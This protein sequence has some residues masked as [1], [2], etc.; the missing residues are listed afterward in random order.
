M[1][2]RKPDA[3]SYWRFLGFVLVFGTI[4]LLNC[5]PV[6]LSSWLNSQ[7]AVRKAVVLQ[8]IDDS[9]E[10]LLLLVQRVLDVFVYDT[11]CD[12]KIA[13]D[14]RLM[15]KADSVSTVLKLWIV[16]LPSVIVTV[17][18]NLADPLLAFLAIPVV[19]TVWYLWTCTLSKPTMKA[20]RM[21]ND[22]NVAM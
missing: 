13:K 22:R 3:A 15:A 1:E 7:T 4:I 10:I 12:H 6:V 9:Q 21:K 19:F 2:P 18:G 20:Q 17:Y 16:K 5:L 11:L 14:R 8:A